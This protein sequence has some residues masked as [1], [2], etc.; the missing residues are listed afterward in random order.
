[1]ILTFV[2]DCNSIRVG[3]EAVM[4]KG[5]KEAAEEWGVEW[6]ESKNWA[7][8]VHLG[9]NLGKRKHQ[10]YRTQKARAAFNLVRRLSRLPPREKRKVVVGQVIPILV[11]G[12]EQHDTQW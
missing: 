1:M 2:D 9:V 8:G 4:D 12:A 11:Y 10:R 5:L 7:N 6:D 3:S